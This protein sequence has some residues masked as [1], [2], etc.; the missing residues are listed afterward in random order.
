MCRKLIYLI[1]FA[2]LLSA[3]SSVQA[4]TIT[5]AKGKGADTYL[6]N[7]EQSGNYGPNSVH[8]T[9]DAF[10]V[11]NVAGV[12]LKIGYVRFDISDVNSKDL[13]GARVGVNT[14][15]G[16]RD[17]TWGIYAL[18]NESLDKW[19]EATTSYSNAP[20]FR[21]APFG[22]YAIDANL[23][24]SV[25]SISVGSA[26]GYYESASSTSMDSFIKSDTNKLLTFALIYETKDTD[27]NPDWR[28][29]SK[30]GDPNLA[31]RL[32]VPSAVIP[33]ASK[34]SPAGGG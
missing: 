17:R 20:G 31:P 33:P 2:M 21:G 26:P 15:S 24:Q 19:D 12:R 1:S 13:M 5:T 18:V 3:A 6:S 28:V 22:Q 30:E 8:G 27:T 16:K 4:L 25:A 14:S 34:P 10:E 7:D 9:E 23:L 29:T 11:R 32:V